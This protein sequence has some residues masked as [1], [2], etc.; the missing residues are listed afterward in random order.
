[1]ETALI[2]LLSNFLIF[3][4]VLTYFLPH[5]AETFEAE[6]IYQNWRNKK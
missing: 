2:I 4:F 3:Y 5:D 1:M 6:E